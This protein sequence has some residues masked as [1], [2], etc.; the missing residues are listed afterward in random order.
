VKTPLVI[1]QGGTVKTPLVIYSLECGHAA[2][3][4]AT[5]VNGKLPC[6]WHE[7]IEKITGVV[8]YEWRAKC[9][10]CSYARWAGTAKHTAE[11]FA[12]G[13]SRRNSTH[14]VYAEYVKNPVAVKTLEKFNAWSGRTESGTV[15]PS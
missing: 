15:V 4:P 3:A 9:D 13:H 7:G 6:M 1:Y 5:L 10:S 12:N 14:R 8:V 2:S 11:L